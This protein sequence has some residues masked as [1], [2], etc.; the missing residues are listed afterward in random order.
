MECDVICVYLCDL[1]AAA[2]MRC[3]LHPAPCILHPTSSI[4]LEQCQRR[5]QRSERGQTA[6]AAAF[7]EGGIEESPTGRS[8]DHRHSG[9]GDL[10]RGLAPAVP[11]RPWE[12]VAPALFLA[13]H[14][15]ALLHFLAGSNDIEIFLL[16][17]EALL[18]VA[19]LA[20]DLDLPEGYR[21]RCRAVGAVV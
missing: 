16:G 4:N 18:G 11:L 15:F 9:D 6:A 17:N 8:A 19:V 12:V 7:A 14:P 3:S 10:G 13:R 20:E 1:W 2:T 21:Y 5:Q